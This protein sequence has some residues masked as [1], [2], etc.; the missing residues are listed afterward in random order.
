MI[1]DDLFIKKQMFYAGLMGAFI[2]I[3]FMRRI[4]PLRAFFAIIGG[5]ACAVYIAP[6]VMAYF[7]FSSADDNAAAFL[8]GVVGMNFIG[9]IFSVGGKFNPNTRKEEKEEKG[10]GK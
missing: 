1:F 3:A 2:S 9:M 6:L 5:T 7:N 10:D 8:T 4:T